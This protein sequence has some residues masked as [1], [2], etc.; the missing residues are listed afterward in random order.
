M[1]LNQA[2]YWLCYSFAYIIQSASFIL[3]VLELRRSFPPPSVTYSIMDYWLTPEDYQTH[4]NTSCT[5]FMTYFAKQN[6]MNNWWNVCKTEEKSL[7]KG[8]VGLFLLVNLLVNRRPEKHIS[9]FG[10]CFNGFA[11]Q[12]NFILD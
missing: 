9:F 4:K 12:N 7:F 11:N 8:R 6:E 10:T 5:L 3:Y 1:K 2:L